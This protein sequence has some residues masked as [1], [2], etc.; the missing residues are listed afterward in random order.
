MTSREPFAFHSAWILKTV[1]DLI[2]ETSL[3]GGG[4]YYNDMTIHTTSAFLTM[5]IKLTKHVQQ[6]LFLFTQYAP[7]IEKVKENMTFFLR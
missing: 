5:P 2:T 1:S 4:E 3:R 7:F 6:S